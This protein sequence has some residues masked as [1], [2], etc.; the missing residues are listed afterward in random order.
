MGNLSKTILFVFALQFCFAQQV[1]PKYPSV[2]VVGKDTLVCFTTEQA[3]QMGVW[4]EERKECLELRKNDNQKISELEK[5]T[6][7]QTGIISNLENEIIQHKKNIEDKDKLI[8][9]C[10]DEKKTLTREIRKQKRGKWI[11]I[12]SGIGGVF[13]TTYILTL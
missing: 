10:E 9:V 7:T 6:T 4:N 5:I 12:F 2:I 11:A 1:K 13:L 3:K 8:G